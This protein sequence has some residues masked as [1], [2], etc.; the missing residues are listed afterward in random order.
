MSVF[1]F[2]NSNIRA[3]KSFPSREMQEKES[4]PNPYFGPAGWA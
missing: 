3:N 4:F 1:D 2:T